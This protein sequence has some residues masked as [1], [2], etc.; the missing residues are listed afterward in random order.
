MLS[1]IYCRTLSHGRLAKP[2]INGR[3]LSQQV[4][5]D[6]HHHWPELTYPRRVDEEVSKRKA[7]LLY[8]SRKR[9]I[10]END[11]LL[12]NFAHH[13]LHKMDNQQL[14]QYDRLLNESSNEWELYYWIIGTKSVPTEFDN[15]IMA[16]LQK[17]ASNKDRETRFHQ[18]PL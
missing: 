15:E 2:C 4:D 5:D 7:R 14:D 6:H 1:L 18:P 16:M 13:F 10:K 8:Q 12:S 9:G 11:L 3:F 17:Y